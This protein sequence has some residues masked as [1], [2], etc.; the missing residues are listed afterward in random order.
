MAV[1]DRPSL[2][3]LRSHIGYPSPHL[4]DTAK[5]H[6]DPFAEEEIRLTKEILGLPPDESFWVPD[7]VLELY[8]ACI[9]RGRAFR[10]DWAGAV[11]RLGRRPGPMGGRARPATACPGGRPSCPPSPRRTGPWPPARPS[12]PA[13]TP[14]ASDPRPHARQRRPDRQH[15]HGHGRRHR[16]VGR[17]ARRQPIHY[18]IREH[19]MGGIMNGMA[20]H[21]GCC[22]SAAPSSSSATTCAARC[23]SPPCPRPTSSTRGPT[24]PSGWRGRA[25][26]PAGR[27]AGRRAGHARAPGDPPGRRQRDRPGLADR[28][29]RRRAHRPDPHPPGPPGAGRDGRPGR[30]RGGPGRPTCSASRRAAQPGWSSSAPAARS[31]SAWPPP[32]CWPPNGVAAR[33][34][35]FP[36]WDLFAAPA[37]RATGTRCCPGGVPAWRSRRPAPSAGT[38]TPTPSV[39]IDHFGASAPGDGGHRGVRLHPRA[40]GH[41]GRRVGGRAVSRGDRILPHGGDPDERTPMTRLHDLYDAAGPEPVARQPAP[42]LARGRDAGRPGRPGH[43]GG[44]LQPD[45]LRQGHR[46]PG[47]LRRAVPVPD[48]RPTSVEDAYWDLVIDDIDDALAILRPVYDASRRRRRLRLGG[49]GAGPGPRHRG[50]HRRGPRPPRAHRPAQPAGQDPGHRRRRPGHPADDRRGPQ[51]QRH[52]DLQP[53]PLRRGHRGLPVG[54]RGPGRLRRGRPVQV[55]PA[56]PRSSSAG[57]TPRSTAGSRPRPGR[58]RTASDLLALRGQAAVAQA[59]LAYHLFAE[60]F[61]GPRWE[62]LAAK[63]ARVQRPLWASTS[64]KNPAYPDLAYV[65]TL[66]GPDTVNTMP[67]ATVADFL[68]HGTV[69]RTVDTGRRTRP[70]GSSTAWPRPASTWPTWPPCSRSRGWPPSPSPSTS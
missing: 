42:G 24:T 38:A 57:S 39:G 44:H 23:G 43:P 17:R 33:V 26:P 7:E 35:S 8:R 5:A 58:R 65:D 3:I 12:R 29:R 52:P 30:A 10:A 46:G 67:D 20:A 34:V 50:H 15:R 60:R 16:P 49:G 13:S 47:H 18:G 69:A 37:R 70:A 32:T 64:T 59:R 14:P 53:R 2:I 28:R 54:P 22:R 11:R 21:G 6:G 4:T 56:W 9:P 68:D 41:R 55:W 51:H 25:H 61:S 45:H 40:R 31:R 62:A 36:S 66:I 48:R 19:G 27:A 63:G 1:E